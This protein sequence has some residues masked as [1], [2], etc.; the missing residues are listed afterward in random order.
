M[1][2]SANLADGHGMVW[3]IGEAPVDGATDFLFTAVLAGV[4]GLG[5]DLEAGAKAIIMICHALTALLVFLT[6]IRLSKW[7]PWLAF[8]FSLFLVV[9]PGLNY[10]SAY[11]A[12]PF[13]V[14]IAAVA[15]YLAC[16]IATK[17]D[18]V[19]NMNWL[20][21]IASLLLGLAR[22]EG[23][24][25][26]LLFLMAVIFIKRRAAL[27]TVVAYLALYLTIGLGYF[28][29]RWDY[30]GHP[31]PNPFYKKGGGQIYLDGL[32]VAF[33]AAVYF[34]LPFVVMFFIAMRKNLRWTVFA[35]IPLVGFTVIWIFLSN[36]MNY[37]FRF[38]YA[39]LP[40][41][42]VSLPLLW[43][44]GSNLRILDLKKPLFALVALFAVVVL[45]FH[46]WYNVGMMAGNSKDGRYDVAVFLSQFRDDGYVIAVSEAGLLPLYS[47]WRAL[48]V[49]GLN[50]QWIAHN[51][52]ITP[53]YLDGYKPDVIMYHDN[54][55][56]AGSRF[57][58]WCEMNSILRDYVVSR[59]YHLAAAFGKSQDDLHYYY[60]SK[61]TEHWK[62]IADGISRLDYFWSDGT[63]A[64]LFTSLGS[65]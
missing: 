12:T 24:V 31:L 27:S 33:K 23:V 55:M 28:L 19:R 47:E 1:R 40:V 32:Y 43:P 10:V 60:V 7:P 16:L 9:G 25:L 2:Y 53:K 13:F 62:V 11:F 37:A 29:W 44:Q 6:M 58:Q 52:S 5:V 21:A 51:G 15:W 64:Q 36:E 20:F 41:A 46:G 49:W 38:Q 26:S 63:R 48:D 57:V 30:F 18:G 3:N 54:C 50:D 45:I 39:L 34:C 35:A 59:N 61:D 22:P 8:F 14:L 56:G 4:N 65:K 17:D 42:L